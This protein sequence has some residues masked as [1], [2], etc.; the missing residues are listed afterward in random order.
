M[1]HQTRRPVGEGEALQGLR[2]GDVG[3]AALEAKAEGQVPKL[4][5]DYALTRWRG[6]KGGVPKGLATS[7][8][9]KKENKIISNILEK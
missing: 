9:G 5:E 1:G 8:N 4:W 7:F 3:E 6:G 2:E